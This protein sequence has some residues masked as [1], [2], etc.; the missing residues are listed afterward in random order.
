MGDNWTSEQLDILEHLKMGDAST[1]LEFLI[2]GES[3][4]QI[5]KIM[6]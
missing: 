2:E 5:S 3:Y 4:A 6:C 1:L